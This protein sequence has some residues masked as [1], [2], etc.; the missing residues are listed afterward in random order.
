LVQ[1]LRDSPD[2]GDG[3]LEWHGGDLVSPRR[4]HRPPF[5]S[6]GGVHGGDAQPGGQDAVGRYRGATPLEWPRRGTR[7]SNPFIRA[8]SG[9]RIAQIPPNRGNPRSS[10]GNS[11]RVSVPAL[12]TAPSATT[13]MEN[14]LPRECRRCRC[15]V[16]SRRSNGISGI[17]IASPP[18]AVPANRAIHPALLPITSTSITLLWLS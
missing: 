10:T 11:G 5:S 3:F 9:P 13:T 17:R 18:P 14:D 7:V 6:R 8:I 16:T 4:H 2:L 15:A 12:G 1:P